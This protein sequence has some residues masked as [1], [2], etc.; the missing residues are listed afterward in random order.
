MRSC[1]FLHRRVWAKLAL[2][3]VSTLLTLALVEGLLRLGGWP[4][5]DPV[6]TTCHETAFRFAPNLGYR[7]M[8]SEYDVEFHTNRLGLRS[9]EIGPKRGFRVLLLGDSY[10]CGYGV[11]RPQIF[12]DRLRERLHVDLV[13]AG[14]GGFEI[15]HQLHY[16]RASGRKLKPDLVVYAL[17]L[18]NDLT[19]NRL[20][21]STADGG[22]RRVDGQSPLVQ[23]GTPKLVC[24]LKRSVPLRRLFHALDGRFEHRKIELPGGEYLGLCADP[25]GQTAEEDYRVAD[26]LLQ[27]LRDEVKASGAEFMVMSIPLRAAVE[28]PSAT[29]YQPDKK[30]DVK[31]DLLR[32]VRIVSDLLQKAGI[33]HVSLTN[34]LRQDRQ[35]LKTPLYFPLDGHLN[36]LGHRCVA[37]HACPA[38]EAKIRAMQAGP[39]R[40]D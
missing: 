5:E 11:E 24:L 3:A 1:R 12:A 25:L 7:H 19:N 40:A 9:D 37:D 30:A 17:Y 35:R 8:S 23:R 29:A 4:P 16:F 18:N 14:V 15:I 10:T 38:L 32:P 2:A 36:A 6:W 13:N 26:E 22:L 39:Q 31:Y 21:E 28:E 20:W 33:E 34:A 27:Q